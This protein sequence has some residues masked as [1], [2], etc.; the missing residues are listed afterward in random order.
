[1]RARICTDSDTG[2]LTRLKAERTLNRSYLIPLQTRYGLS[3]DEAERQLRDYHREPM[4]L[5]IALRPWAGQAGMHPAWHRWISALMSKE[6][7]SAN[8]VLRRSVAYPVHA[9]RCERSTIAYW[10]LRRQSLSQ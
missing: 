9:L 8:G 1:M 6:R 10:G 2:S 3:R 7:R 4:Q 5:L